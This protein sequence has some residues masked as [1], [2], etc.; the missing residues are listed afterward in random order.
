MPG[1]LK[2]EGGVE[3]RIVLIIIAIILVMSFLIYT[4]LKVRDM[5]G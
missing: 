2:K 4:V 3:A 5:L 1:T